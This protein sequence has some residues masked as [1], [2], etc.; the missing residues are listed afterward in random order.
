M[1]NKF[2]LFYLASIVLTS[3][4]IISPIKVFSENDTLLSKI[5]LL[6]GKIYPEIEYRFKLHNLELSQIPRKSPYEDTFISQDITPSI[7]FK[8]YKWLKFKAGVRIR[9]IIGDDVDT[10]PRFG[11]NITSQK[12][13]LILGWYRANLTP[14]TLHINI[15]QDDIP[16]L[17]YLFS[18]KYIG[19]EIILARTDLP[20]ES[21]YET[22]LWAGKFSFEPTEY[23]SIEPHLCIYHQGGFDKGGLGF[24]PP[25][26]SKIE[27][28]LYG[29]VISLRSPESG[30]ID[31]VNGEFE[32]NYGGRRDLDYG[33]LYKFGGGVKP[34]DYLEFSTDIYIFDSNY[35]A[36]LGEDFLLSYKNSNQD[37]SGGSS[38]KNLYFEISGVFNKELAENLNLYISVSQGFRNDVIQFNNWEYTRSEVSTVLSLLL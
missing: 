21:S 2:L 10:S 9:H 11:L 4:I 25:E 14:A 37:L 7:I 30:V 23:I 8:P 5:N 24:E 18:D 36:P 16:G 32:F 17:H 3:I 19:F 27:H 15:N 22:Y 13:N 33:F 6:D 35:R 12:H 28:L 38:D 1:R 20:D 31:E 29:G 34:A 26:P